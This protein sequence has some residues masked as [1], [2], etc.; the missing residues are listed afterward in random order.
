M[1]RRTMSWVATNVQKKSR[2]WA[3]SVR[4]AEG[5]EREL[6]YKSEAQARYFAAVLALG[7]SRL[8][9]PPKKKIVAKLRAQSK[10]HPHAD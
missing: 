3:V 10:G 6:T 4:S 2:Q 1:I 8:P 7:P 9:E 5:E